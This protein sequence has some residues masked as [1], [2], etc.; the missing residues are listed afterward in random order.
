MDRHAERRMAAPATADEAIA[1]VVQYSI[2]TVPCSAVFVPTQSGTTARMISRFKPRVWIV[3]VSP[4]AAVCQGLAFS[5]GVRAIQV[6]DEPADWR[7]FAGDW[8]RDHE[9]PAAPRRP[10]RRPFRAK[11]GRQL[12]RRV[13]AL[14][15]T[16]LT[17]RTN[18]Y[19]NQNNT[20][21]NQSHHRRRSRRRSFVRRA[22]AEAG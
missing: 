21:G 9:V 7:E 12:P 6:A 20:S 19:G 2:G 15:S 11:P 18:I 13:P 17:P 3:G 22:S 16:S 10:G 5:Y 8:L 14:C 4:D 1:D